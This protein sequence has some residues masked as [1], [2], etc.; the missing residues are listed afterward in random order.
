MDEARR[1]LSEMTS[2]GIRPCSVTYNTFV[3]GFAAQG[4]FSEVNDVISYMIEH[5]CRPNMLTYKTI[6]DGYCRAKKYQEALEFVG[7]I[8]KL[9]GSFDEQSLQTLAS[10][11]RANVVL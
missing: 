2:K 9:D 4:L 10:I 6:V 8:R 3:A 1:V 11:A 5:N 7:N